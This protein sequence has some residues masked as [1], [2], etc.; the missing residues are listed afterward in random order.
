M[1]PAPESDLADRGLER[2]RSTSPGSTLD[3]RPFSGEKG[4]RTTGPCAPKSAGI[5]TS[6]API[7]G[8]HRCFALGTSSTPLRQVRRKVR[9]LS[10]GE[11]HC[12]E[13]GS[14]TTL[15][16]GSYL[17]DSDCKRNPRGPR[18]HIQR[19]AN[20]HIINNPI[21]LLAHNLLRFSRAGAMSPLMSLVPSDLLTN[22]NAFSYRCSV[23]LLLSTNTD[24]ESSK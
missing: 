7:S 14:C 18:Q 6:H 2:G 16:L 13:H 17:E 19:H 9:G 24:G 20:G 1:N 3:A 8:T 4:W 11:L 21:H 15:E 22:R 12:S 10:C 5:R 23:R